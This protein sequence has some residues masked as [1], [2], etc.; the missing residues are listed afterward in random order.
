MS[1]ILDA[2]RQS[3]HRR[4]RAQ[5]PHIHNSQM[6]PADTNTRTT[7]RHW[8]RLLAL[9]LFILFALGAGYWMGAIGGRWLQQDDVSSRLEDHGLPAADPLDKSAPAFP[10][11]SIIVEPE[12]HGVSS[13]EPTRLT[14]RVD[15]PPAHPPQP[16][17]S[18]TSAAPEAE[19]LTITAAEPAPGPALDSGVI[20]M[21]QLPSAI[22]ARLPS[23]ILSVHIY[24]DDAA[25]RMVNINGQML[26]E[27]QQIS[28]ALQLIRITPQGIILNFEDIE[29]HMNSVGS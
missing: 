6:V 14:I 7:A 8:R 1:Y 3:E 13:P 26:R 20:D 19:P 18:L 24:S 2:L 11:T 22:Q 10:A 25:S 4:R 12:D 5:S 29:F 21:R 9:I 16:E 27:G 15:E 17:A 23:L 28:P